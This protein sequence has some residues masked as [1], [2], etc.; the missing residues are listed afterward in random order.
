[1]FQNN[2]KKKQKQNKPKKTEQ[3]KHQLR[4]KWIILR[5]LKIMFIKKKISAS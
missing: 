3:Y 4:S 2:N 5:G 1:M